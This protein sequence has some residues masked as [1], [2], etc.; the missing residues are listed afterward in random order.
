[1]FNNKDYVLSVERHKSFS[2]AAKELYISQPSLSASIK[3]IENEI[4]AP[5]FDRSTNPL[6]LTEIGQKYV[7]CA[8]QINDIEQNFINYIGDSMNMLTGGI[9][10]GGSSMFTSFVLP[11]LISNFNKLYPKIEFN[12]MEGHTQSLI[13]MLIAGELDLVVENVLISNKSIV[14]IILTSEVL[15]LA[16][17]NSFKVNEKLKDKM[18]TAEDI[19]AGRHNDPSAPCVKLDSFK[20][21]PFI[22][23]KSE[24]DTGKRAKKLCKKHDFKPNVIFKLDQQMTAYNITCSGVGI[25]FISD[26]IIKHLSASPDVCYYK[27]DDEDITRNI[28]FYVKNNRYI[29][30][31]CQSFIDLCIKGNNTVQK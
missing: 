26:T 8:L 29:S 31:A 16:V 21:E 9:K 5:I 25:S 24:N 4:G 23:L 14:P 6:S 11:P 2:K 19:K 27:L 30:K 10:I 18:L 28:Y 1:M 20:D 22:L 13:N 17:P 15:M 12:F 7:E 3:R